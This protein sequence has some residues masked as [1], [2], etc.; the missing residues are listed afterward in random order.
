MGS[1]LV[2][3]WASARFAPS[4]PNEIMVA[5]RID[6]I[7][8]AS[9]P[10]RVCALAR[11]GTEDRVGCVCIG[12]FFR[13]RGLRLSD[14]WR[15][16]FPPIEATGEAE[17]AEE[18][19]VIGETMMTSVCGRGVSENTPTTEAVVTALVHTDTLAL[20]KN[21]VWEAALAVLKE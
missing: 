11:L 6:L 12:L 20:L 3:G 21:A 16:V 10:S 18:K 9:A 7:F 19:D 5:A 14:G 2:W 4:R 17:V 1:G 8:M 15:E 13:R